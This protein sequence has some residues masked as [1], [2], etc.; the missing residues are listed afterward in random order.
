MSR[1]HG[2]ARL[3]LILA[4]IL[5]GL[6][7]FGAFAQAANPA[8]LDGTIVSVDG[9]TVTVTLADGTR[10]SAQLQAGTLILE[11][12]VATVDQLQPG[13]AMGVAARR[14]GT[15]LI[16]TNINIFA[17][18]LWD[19]VR[20]GQ[21]P[22]TTG[23]VMTNAMATDY[24]PGTSGHTLTMKYR[25]GTA[26]ITVHDGVPVHRLVSMPQ[27]ALIVGLHV[28]IRGSANADGSLKA[29]SVSFEGAA[30]G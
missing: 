29:A 12:E 15:E 3:S 28:V 6:A 13:E 22:M 11:R 4:V 21:W 16:A 26:T 1:L 8:S 19:V 20:K 30:K 23:E 9:G 17:K 24:L 2:F 18:E 7:G 25:D 5:F 10:K 27:A 14:S